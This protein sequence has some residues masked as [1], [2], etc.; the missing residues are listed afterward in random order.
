[1]SQFFFPACNLSFP[2]NSYL[3]HAHSHSQ[4]TC[5]TT[6]CN[7][8]IH[9]PY[10]QSSTHTTNEINTCTHTNV[11]NKQDATALRTK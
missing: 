2:N 9:T 5:L 1:M 3:I 11:T 4:Q 6:I 7:L 8:V 10:I